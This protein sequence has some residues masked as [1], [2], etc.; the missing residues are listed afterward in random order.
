MTLMELVVVL[1]IIAILA[2]ISI[3][4]VGHMKTRAKA[5][6]Q[7]Q[8]LAGLSQA[9]GAYYADNGNVYP[10]S[11]NPLDPTGGSY[12]SGTNNTSS[13]MIGQGRGAA[14]LAQGLMGYLPG[15]LDGAGASGGFYA[16]D[17]T[18]GFRTHGVASTGAATGQIH[19]P[20][21][22]DDSKYLVNHNPTGT[23]L[24]GTDRSFI[25]VYGN[26][27][28]YF[29][30][31][32]A[33]TDRSG[34]PVV[35]K[36]FGTDLTSNGNNFYFYTNDNASLPP[37]S[38]SGTTARVSPDTASAFLSLLG[39]SSNDI[40]SGSANILGATSFLLISPGPDGVPFTSDDIVIDNKQ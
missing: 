38:P 8:Q 11:D 27:I 2:A 4:V 18:Y 21:G 5:A 13:P 15:T 20:Y 37:D 1:A 7:R 30:S 33:V 40:T 22:P 29:R 19:G 3:P 23:P 16:G 24:P 10:P 31:T 26:E 6:A 32:R 35:T 9:L 12:G 17:P 14:L 34:L 39:A 36:V 25:D 28:L